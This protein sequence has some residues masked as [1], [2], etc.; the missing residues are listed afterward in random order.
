MEMYIDVTGVYL[1]SNYTQQAARSG[2]G[3]GK[4]IV[5]LFVAQPK[6]CKL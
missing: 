5:L 2:V 3:F 4:N 1:N 6:A